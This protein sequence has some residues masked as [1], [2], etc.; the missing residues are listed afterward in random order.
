[1]RREGGPPEEAY[2]EYITA[3]RAEHPSKK[4]YFGLLK[5]ARV[6]KPYFE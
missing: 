5:Q 6:K 2:S 3:A 4:P 1:M